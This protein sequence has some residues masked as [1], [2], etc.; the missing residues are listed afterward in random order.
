VA[1]LIRWRRQRIRISLQDGDSPEVPAWVA[2]GLAVH[3]LRGRDHVPGWR[4]THVD[5]GQGIQP[6]GLTRARAFAFARALLRVG[7]WQ[8]DAEHVFGYKARAMRVRKRIF[9]HA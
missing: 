1:D 3:F 9:G 7:E 6:W 2:K 4:V 5:S 8:Q